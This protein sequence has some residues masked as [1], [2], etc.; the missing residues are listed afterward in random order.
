MPQANRAWG[1][2]AS[3]ASRTTAALG[4]PCYRTPHAVRAPR[5]AA[6]MNRA[7]PRRPIIRYRSPTHRPVQPAPRAR[8][9][10]V[11]A[12]PCVRAA[13]PWARGCRARAGVAT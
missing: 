9:A 8:K 1:D 11:W 3:S 2:P 4:R 5:R 7:R 12:R 10:A 6:Q 13:S